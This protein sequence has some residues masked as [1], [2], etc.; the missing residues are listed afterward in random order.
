MDCWTAILRTDL[1]FCTCSLRLTHRSRCL[2]KLFLRINCI[3]IPALCYLLL[4]VVL[5][6]RLNGIFQAMP[7]HESRDELVAERKK[8]GSSGA[9]DSL[10][11]LPIA[12]LTSKPSS[13]GKIRLVLELTTRVRNTQPFCTCHTSGPFV[14][15]HC[16]PLLGRSD[17]RKIRCSRANCTCGPFLRRDKS[18]WLTGLSQAPSPSSETV[19]SHSHRHNWD[20]GSLLGSRKRSVLTGHKMGA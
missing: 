6:D 18:S 19:P 12:F 10:V 16:A 13:R 7:P 3:R 14:L 20:S 5:S 9:P 2:S 8:K 11:R 17:I 15:V 4:L 1:H